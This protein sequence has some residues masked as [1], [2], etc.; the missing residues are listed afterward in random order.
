MLRRDKLFI[1]GQWVAPSTQDS[2]DVHSAGTGEVMGQ[3][4][5]GGEKDIDAA[6]KAAHAA[7]EGWSQIPADKRAEFLQKISDGLKARADEIAKTIA[8][9]VGMPIKLAGRIQAGL[10][11]A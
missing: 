5:A 9:E 1:G 10:P 6:A 7:L 4:P 11:I 3:V 8:Q 2:I